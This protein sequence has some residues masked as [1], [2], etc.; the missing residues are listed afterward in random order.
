M[1][2]QGWYR[3]QVEKV[4]TKQLFVFTAVLDTKTCGRCRS[5]HGSEVEKMEDIE[6]KQRTPIHQGCRCL[7]LGTV[8]KRGANN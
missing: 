3:K 7:W 4:N 8:K 5:L 6:S 2:L 1:R